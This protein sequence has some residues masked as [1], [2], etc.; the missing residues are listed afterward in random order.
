MNFDSIWCLC[1]NLRKG[2]GRR[3]RECATQTGEL[4]V[5]GFRAERH[6]IS[7][8]ELCSGWLGSHMSRTTKNPGER[9]YPASVISRG[10]CSEDAVTQKNELL[11]TQENMGRSSRALYEVH[12]AHFIHGSHVT[13]SQRGSGYFPIVLTKKKNKKKINKKF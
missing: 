10:P 9:K 13:S 4:P 2:P 6:C 7:S 5:G 3:R 11:K 12:M 1:L 8:R